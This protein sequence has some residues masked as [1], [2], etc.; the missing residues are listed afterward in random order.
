MPFPR[1]QPGP[2]GAADDP[3]VPGGW[4][5]AHISATHEIAALLDTVAGAMTGLAF[6]D[7]DAFGVRL[8]LEEALVNA[9][10]HG[11]GYDPTKQVVIRYKVVPEYAL[12]EVED[13][14]PGFDP[15]Q[16]PDPT[17]PEN[18]ERPCGRGL[19]LMRTYAS[20]IR[21]NRRGNC[22]T[23][24]KYRSVHPAKGASGQVIVEEG[25]MA[26]GLLGV[27]R[28]GDTLVITALAD[29]GELEFQQIGSEARHV[30][31]LVS[32]PSVR[33]IVLDFQQTAYY[34]SSALG[35]FVRLWKKVSS[36]G[37]RIACCNLSPVEKEIL[38]FTRLDSLWPICVS[39]EEAM[40]EVGTA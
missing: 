27:E 38:R 35:F 17:A 30:L 11:H 9:V 6:P 2:A 34:G 26:T 7:K 8:A 22:V 33:N 10:K 39:R 1:D 18:L 4:H 29:L 13:Q 5:L 25:S 16:V 15:L 28:V 40:Q 20:S 23:L 36:R 31:D 12:V 24:C 32:D 37:G 19:L 21:H 14:G 3:K